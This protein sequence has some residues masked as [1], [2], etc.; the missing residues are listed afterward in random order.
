MKILLNLN[1]CAQV[2]KLWTDLEPF[3]SLSDLKF[4]KYVDFGGCSFNILIY[5]LLVWIVSMLFVLRAPCNVLTFVNWLCAFC[6]YP[7]AQR[8]NK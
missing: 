4:H 8:L 6:E 3:S 7:K 5:Y 1:T 2:R